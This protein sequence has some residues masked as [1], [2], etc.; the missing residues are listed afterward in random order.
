VAGGGATPPGGA[1]TGGVPAT[2]GARASR[3]LRGVIPAVVESTSAPRLPSGKLRVRVLPGDATISVDGR[4]LGQSAVIDSAVPAGRRLLHVAA[5][6]Y[7]SFDTTITLVGD[8]T[9]VLGTVTLK[10][11]SP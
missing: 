9:T 2:I 4:L 1:S 5:P 6:G 10:P 11:S 7:Q 3:L 8:S